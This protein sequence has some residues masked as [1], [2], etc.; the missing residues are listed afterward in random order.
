VAETEP[1]LVDDLLK[2]SERYES[3]ELKGDEEDS[4]LLAA[5]L[6]VSVPPCSFGNG[7]IFKVKVG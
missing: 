5:E 1:W 6:D 3:R 7:F 2:I 4:K